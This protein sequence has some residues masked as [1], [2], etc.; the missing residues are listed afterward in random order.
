MEK[1]RTDPWTQWEERREKGRCMERKK[2]TIPY[3]KQT[4][5]GNLLYDLGNSNK[6][7][8][9][10]LKGGMVRE[11]G[12]SSENEGTWVYLWLILVDV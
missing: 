2:F 3:I 6:G 7:L 10:R 4:T 9:N 11:R 8:C 1:Q 5:D 12:A